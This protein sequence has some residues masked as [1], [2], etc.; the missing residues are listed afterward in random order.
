M[1]DEILPTMNDLELAPL[2]IPAISHDADDFAE[3]IATKLNYK[4]LANPIR[5]L[6]LVQALSCLGIMILSLESV[7]KYKMAIRIDERR[8][9]RKRPAI[10]FE[11]FL[12]L[13]VFVVC[14]IGYFKIHG[15]LK[16]L[17]ILLGLVSGG[18]HFGFWVKFNEL[19]VW[20]SQT[21][22]YYKG[23]QPPL[24]I[25][26]KALMVKEFIPEA[27]IRVEFFAPTSDPLLTVDYGGAK[28]YIA[29]WNENDY[30]L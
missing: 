23:A 7:A 22:D 29:V 15:D 13:A 10:W 9:L 5:Q 24:Q 20:W 14:A 28:Y 30:R 18:L 17:P 3:R 25:L 27:N 8:K 12:S 11:L 21:L 4:V 1:K 16:W 6:K 2:P 26:Q 19:N